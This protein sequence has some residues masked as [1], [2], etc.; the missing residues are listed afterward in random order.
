VPGSRQGCSAELQLA[1]QFRDLLR[2][3]IPGVSA[4]PS[5]D[6]LFVWNVKV[7]K[8]PQV[9]M[10]ANLALNA[11]VEQCCPSIEE[12]YTAEALTIV[13]IGCCCCCCC[14][15]CSIIVHVFQLAGPEGSP[16]EG[17]WFDVCLEFTEYFPGQQPRAYFK[18]KIWH[19]NV[20][21]GSRQYVCLA[22][23]TYVPF[24]HPGFQNVCSIACVLVGLQM[25]LS[26]PN[27]NNPLNG[28]CAAQMRKKP[29]Q[30]EAK[31]RSWTRQYAM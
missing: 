3:P 2:N 8:S 22:V 4:A 21:A 23:G 31:A 10:T 6:D 20:S 1:R 14:C 29:Q 24:D 12:L 28:P 5:E 11:I 19:P 7:G 27:P 16:Y 9:I 30:Y 15:C 26:S 17:G 13:M 25:L 18:T